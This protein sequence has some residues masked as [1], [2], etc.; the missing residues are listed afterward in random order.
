MH[1]LKFVRYSF[2]A[3]TPRTIK[4]QFIELSTLFQVNKDTVLEWAVS[5]RLMSGYYVLFNGTRG[6]IPVT[7]ELWT[8]LVLNN[9]YTNSRKL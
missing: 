5:K 6:P 1:L 4:F 7:S 2:A 8:R 9:I 3:Q